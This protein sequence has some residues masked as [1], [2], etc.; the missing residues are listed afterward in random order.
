M[1]RKEY[2]VM[3]E[4]R[5]NGGDLFT[6]EIEDFERLLRD[7][8]HEVKVT[9]VGFTGEPQAERPGRTAVV[10]K[11]EKARRARVVRAHLAR[12]IDLQKPYMREHVKREWGRDPDGAALTR[13]RLAQREL[14]A[15][16]GE[17]EEEGRG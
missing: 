5:R 14:E 11:A 6:Y 3:I 1:K 8:E 10:T 4:P 17:L 12:F 2:K 16:I 9:V 15:L 13:L 7:A